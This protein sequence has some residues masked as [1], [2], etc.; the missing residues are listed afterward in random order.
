MKGEVRLNR[1]ETSFAINFDH[2][3]NRGAL[4]LSPACSN[5]LGE[6]DA[7]VSRNVFTSCT[8][9]SRSR[10]VVGLRRNSE[11]RDIY[12]PDN[13]I[14]AGSTMFIRPGLIRRQTN[15]A[16]MPATEFEIKAPRPAPTVDFDL[17]NPTIVPLCANAVVEALSPAGG[18]RGTGLVGTWKIVS[19]KDPQGNNARGVVRNATQDVLDFANRDNDDRILLEDSILAAG[20]EYTIS[21]TMEN[22]YSSVLERQVSFAVTSQRQPSVSFIRRP[23]PAVLSSSRTRFLAQVRLPS[24]DVN[25]STPREFEFS[26]DWSVRDPDN[27]PLSV[28]NFLSADPRR[29]AIPPN[30]LLPFLSPYTVDFSVSAKP[31]NPVQ[32]TLKANRTISVQVL[33][34]SMTSV[35]RGGDRVVSTYSDLV[36]DGSDSF[37]PDTQLDLPGQWNIQLSYQWSCLFVDFNETSCS[38]LLLSDSPTDLPILRLNASLLEL[39]RQTIGVVEVAIRFNLEATST[40][41]RSQSDN[42]PHISSDESHVIITLLGDKTPSV[43]LEWRSPEATKVNPE[44]QISIQMNVDTGGSTEETENYW[45]MLEGELPQAQSLE[46]VIASDISSS[47]LLI[48]P[49]KLVPGISYVFEYSSAFVSSQS[50]AGSSVQIVVNTPPEGGVLQI[51]GPQTTIVSDITQVR[52]R[53]PGWQDEDRPLQYAF[54]ASISGDIRDSIRLRD[55]ASSPNVN[56]RIPTPTDENQNSVTMIVQVRD[57]LGAAATMSIVVEISQPK[58]EDRSAIA[59]TRVGDANDCLA[60]SDFGCTVQAASGGFRILPVDEDSRRRF[61]GDDAEQTFND[62]LDTLEDA[63]SV[64]EFSDIKDLV[65]TSGD[66]VGRTEFLTVANTNRTSNLLNTA[67]TTSLARD[68]DDEDS[69][70]ADDYARGFVR[71]VSAMLNTVAR[72]SDEVKLRLSKMLTITG[73]NWMLTRDSTTSRTRTVAALFSQVPAFCDQVQSVSLIVRKARLGSKETVLSDNDL[74]GV[75]ITTYERDNC[76]ATARNTERF[77]SER[78]LT[79]VTTESFSDTNDE[80]TI[81]VEEWVHSLFG[82]G[83]DIVAAGLNGA[84]A[85]RQISQFERFLN[86]TLSPNG[87]ALESPSSGISLITSKRR[88]LRSSL[89]QLTPLSFLKSGTISRPSHI[90]RDVASKAAKV[91][92]LNS[93]GENIQPGPDARLLLQLPLFPENFT[94][95]SIAS[96]PG[97]L[98][99]VQSLPSHEVTCPLSTDGEATSVSIKCVNSLSGTT[100]TET[101]SCEPSKSLAQVRFTC[102]DS[103]LVPIIVRSSVSGTTR[104]WS[105]DTVQVSGFDGKVVQGVSSDVGEFTSTLLV[106]DTNPFA[107]VVWVAASPTPTPSATPSVS[108]SPSSSSSGTVS[109]SSSA[110]ATPSSSVTRSGTVSPSPPRTGTPSSTQTGTASQTPTSSSTSSGTLSPSSSVTVTGTAAPPPDPDQEDD[111]SELSADTIALIVSIVVVASALALYTFVIVY[112]YRTKKRALARGVEGADYAGRYRGLQGHDVLIE[113]DEGEDLRVS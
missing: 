9:T 102:G 106:V 110:T 85:D 64:F 92:V 78:A 46:D 87:N 55:F 80:G 12:G 73:R 99:E 70:F 27:T 30:T 50:S 88:S 3:T 69:V 105:D 52:L 49:N 11:I 42:D 107:Q 36:V 71:V 112:R 65:D 57:R 62:L 8:W 23:P 101:I 31:F 47:L 40:L 56:T 43:S 79:S 111:S 15:S 54:F 44:D 13:G 103:V 7:F 76:S 34:S 22:E 29:L 72:E 2:P 60:L 104:S 82:K 96:I 16:P 63:V 51:V 67:L 97:V 38:A 20:H 1:L 19:I 84:E 26:F 66:I 113:A 81:I 35:I 94:L 86:D 10:L 100:K 28:T 48:E 68:P 17:E 109:P 53:A 93:E 95:A 41:N 4:G 37:N 14:Q 89:R 5:L 58:S 90:S 83:G 6:T 45:K 25:S 59:G 39:T 75:G 77:T 74:S 91:A 24:C 108:P 33:P 61:L 18:G 98:K 32:D 21:L